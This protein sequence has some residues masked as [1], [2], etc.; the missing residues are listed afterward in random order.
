VRPHQATFVPDS[1]GQ[2]TSDH[3]WNL[4]A[5]GA[6]L[7]PLIDECRALG[8]RVSLFMDAEP[9]AMALARAVGADRVELYTEPYAAATA[10]RAGRRSWRVLPRPRRPRWPRAWA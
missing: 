9:E 1:E 6:R 4:A 2:F 3:G 7:K 8:V 5:D 10:R